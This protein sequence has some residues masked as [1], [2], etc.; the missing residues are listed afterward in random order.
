MQ[1]TCNTKPLVD[2]VGLA[3][4]DS[5]VNKNYRLSTM[6][7]LAISDKMLKVNAAAANILS[8]A[9][10][11]GKVQAGLTDENGKDL[12]IA[13][14]DTA[15]F[16]KLIGTIET[17]TVTI[18][19]VSGG[20]V[21]HSGAS[22]FTFP[23]SVDSD[24]YT[25]PVP[26]MPDYKAE[27]I[28]VKKADWK[29]IDDNQMFALANSFIHPVYNNV[30]I[31]DDGKVLVGDFDSSLFTLSK[32]GSLGEGCLLPE[33]IVNLLNAVPEGA[34]LVKLKDMYQIQLQ[35]DAY[36][37]VAQFTPKH[38]GEGDEGNYHSDIILSQFKTDVQG[39]VIPL[40]GVK[41][42][43]GQASILRSSG[44]T[45][46]IDIDVDT[47]NL[48][49]HNSEVRGKIPVKPLKAGSVD[50][51][52]TFYFDQLDNVISHFNGETV[53]ACPLIND[54]SVDGIVLYDGEMSAILADVEE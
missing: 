29:F 22:K 52:I 26:D 14:V 42:I 11:K 37:Y 5:N 9:T 44:T 51:N 13:Q 43:L 1:F 48:T 24:D 21:L 7:Q 12:S 45:D 34:R 46:T 23:A 15:K 20:I 18:E 31:G 35:T 25:M 2:S 41:K 54:G 50:F 27:S 36:E 3:V 49:I 17:D 38:E 16:K 32:H 19:F 40:A 39:C 28:E 4:I 47:D 8:Q 6:L 30:W 10:I 53:N 33:T